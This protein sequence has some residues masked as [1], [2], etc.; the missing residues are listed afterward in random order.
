MKTPTEQTDAAWFSCAE[1]Q[2]KVDTG[3]VLVAQ[4]EACRHIYRIISGTVCGHAKN[5]ETDYSECSATVQQHGYEH[6]RVGAGYY[7]CA[8]EYAKGMVGSSHSLI[9]TEPTVVAS[10]A[11]HAGADLLPMVL[12]NSYVLQQQLA[13]RACEKEHMA[14]QLQRAENATTLAQLTAGVAHELNNAVGVLA[15]RTDFVATALWDFLE[16]TDKNNALLFSFGIEDNSYIPA[17]E[18]RTAARHYERVLGMSQEAAKVLAHLFPDKNDAELLAPQFVEKVQ[19]YYCF[20]EMGHDLRDMKV[21]AKQ[22][23]GI[24]RAV[25]LLGGGNSMREPGCDVVQSVRDA[26]MLLHNKIK[27]INVELD[28]QETPTITA[29][30][31]ELVQ[32]W[33]NFIKNGWDAMTEFNTPNPTIRVRTYHEPAT[34]DSPEYAVVR[35][36]NN[37]PPIAPDHI[38]KIWK[39]NF[40]TKKLGSD[41]GLGLGLSIVRRIIDTNNALVDVRSDEQETSFTVR[42]PLTQPTCS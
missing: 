2:R 10:A 21:A 12:H 9:A 25:K 20:W 8:E 38:D 37:G 35:I 34:T 15:R 7:L 28:L 5:A 41:S 29:D 33:V 3:E 36:A 24:V 19:K 39:A 30:T 4:G 11:P 6:F 40:S 32:I 16:Q 42:L 18:L 22:A 13:T 27:R 14:D 1:Q 31:T 23:T 17:R 26:L